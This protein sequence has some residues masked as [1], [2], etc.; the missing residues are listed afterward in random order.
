MCFI[1]LHNGHNYA[2]IDDVVDQLRTQLDS[3]LDTIQSRTSVVSHQLETV[4]QYRIQLKTNLNV[5]PLMVARSDYR[6]NLRVS[7]HYIL[8]T[9]LNLFF[10]NRFLRPLSTDIL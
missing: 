3:L 6:E 2:G 5:R 8:R 7:D 9:F 1:Q 10:K 4:E